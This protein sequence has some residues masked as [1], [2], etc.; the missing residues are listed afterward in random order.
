ME[1]V[2]KIYSHPLYKEL[3]SQIEQAEKDRIYCLHSFS[4]AIDCARIA[5]ILAL[6]ECLPI[7][8]DII[9]AAAL[10][11]DIGRAGEYTAGKDHR[12]ESVRLASE[13]LPQCG[14]S[15]AEQKEII[16]AIE[17]HSNSGGEGL[18]SLLQRADKLS[19]RCFECKSI[20]SCKW[21]DD[22]LNMIIM[23]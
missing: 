20:H 23:Y 19:R 21:N 17:N 13:I 11:H 3:L 4:H 10:L 22:K 15:S 5:Y 18:C 12:E 6:E 14:F 1:R 9:Y 7:K 16:S 2:N 8:K